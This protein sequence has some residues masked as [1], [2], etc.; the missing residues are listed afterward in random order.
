MIGTLALA[1]IFPFAGFWSKDEILVDRRA[2]R[3]RGVHGRRPRRRVPDRGLHDPLRLPHVLRRVPRPRA[4]RTSRRRRSRCR[5]II[6]AVLS[7][8]RRPRST[9]RRSASRSSPSGS[10]RVGAVPR[11]RAPPDVRL[12]ARRRSRS[13]SRSLAIGIAAFFWFRA[14]GARARSRASPSAT[15]WRT[16]GYTF[17][18]NKYYLDDLYEDVIVAGDQGPDR[19]GVVLVQPA[20][21]RRRGER[22]RARAPRVSAAARYDVVDQEAVDGA[23]NGHRPRDRRGRRRCCASSSR[24]ECSATRCSC[25]RPWGSS[26]SL[27]RR[28]SLSGGDRPQMDWFDDWALTLAVFLP[29]RRAWRSCCSSRRRRR[30][31]SRSSRSSRR[32]S[33]SRSASA[34]SPTSTTTAPAM[35]QFQVNEAWIDVINARYHL[36]IDGISLPLLILSMFITRAVRHLLVEPL[37]GAAQPEGVPRADPPARGR[38][39]RHVRR[40]GPHPLLHLLRDRPAPDVLHDRRL[41]RSEPRVRVDQV[42]P[43][44]AVRLGADA[45]ELPGALLPVEAADLRHRRRSSSLARRRASRTARSC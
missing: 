17:L 21:H 40:P 30:R 31:R 26:A 34:S 23:V 43:L 8:R 35:L 37:P 14:R 29:A 13:R 39:E 36:G 7:H 11:A 42:L 33:R 28:S 5:S 1:G 6:L 10:S 20:R 16:A 9:P 32:W 25:S 3:L 22:R 45:A 24:V 4:T 38:H 44:H 15:G 19:P 27:H 41:G 2:E 18:V 12:R